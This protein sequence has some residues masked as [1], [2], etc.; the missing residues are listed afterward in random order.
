V[1]F[2]RCDYEDARRALEQL[3]RELMHLNPSAARRLGE[4]MEET[5]TIHRFRLPELLR[6]SLAS[7]K[8]IESVF[9]GVEEHCGRVKRWR[10]GDHLQRWVALC[11]AQSGEPLSS[12]QGP[13][14]DAGV[15]VCS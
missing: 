14:G 15:V 5:L 7:T 2:T 12:P 11:L 13:Q 8:I 10:A 9:S 6:R 3:L 4:G 1:R